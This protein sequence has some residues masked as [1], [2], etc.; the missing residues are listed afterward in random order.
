MLSGDQC[1]V[2]F[3]KCLMVGFSLTLLTLASDAPPVS[4]GL[5]NLSA[6]DY[7]PTALA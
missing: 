7:A 2:E 1:T 3:N 6:Y 5:R 4:P